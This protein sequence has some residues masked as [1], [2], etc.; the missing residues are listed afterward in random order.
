MLVSLNFPAGNDE[1]NEEGQHHRFFYFLFKEPH[2]R[3]GKQLA[4]E[5]HH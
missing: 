4:K 2:R 1:R 3:R 5:Q